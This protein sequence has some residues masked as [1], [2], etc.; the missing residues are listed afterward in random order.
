MATLLTADEL[1]KALAGL[2]GWKRE[3][4]GAIAKGFRLA[5]HVA[6]IGLVMRVAT[7][8]EVMNHH[9][10]VSWVYNRVTFRL[11]THDA[12]GVTGLDVELARR[13]EQLAAG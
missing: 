4:D 8:A 2:P 6:A 13:I 3:G 12:G 10:E 5:D 7:V 9:P 11:S 1:E